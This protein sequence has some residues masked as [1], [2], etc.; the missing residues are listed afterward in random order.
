MNKQELINEIKNQKIIAVSSLKFDE[1]KNQFDELE[2]HPT[3]MSGD[4][5]VFKVEEGFMVVEEP[6]PQ[7]RSIR[8]FK[9]KDK[10]DE[11]I[12]NRLDT[13]E[14]MWDGCGCKIDFKK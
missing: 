11:F 4:I 9:V 1:L 13:Y 5:V 6:S 3:F 8:Y 12:T 10:L 14:R 7:E 2:R